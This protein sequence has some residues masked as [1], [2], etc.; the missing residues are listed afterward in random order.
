LYKALGG[1]W[2]LGGQSARL[3]VSAA[4]QAKM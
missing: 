3:A 2:D 1:G 4:G